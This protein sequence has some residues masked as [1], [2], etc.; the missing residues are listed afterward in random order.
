[1]G[2]VLIPYESIPGIRGLMSVCNCGRSG[3]LE[4]VCSLTA[5]EKCL[6]PFCL[7]GHPGH[8]LSRSDNLRQAAKLARDLAER[9]DPMCKVIFQ[10]QAHAIALFWDVMLNIFDPNALIVGGEA[11]EANDD[12]QRWFIDEIR[13]ALPTQREDPNSRYAQRRYGRCSRRGNRSAKVRPQ[14]QHCV[15]KEH[16]MLAANTHMCREDGQ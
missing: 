7:A 16:T 8:E 13:A 9:G 4:S 12:F 6:L 15:I 1:V 3:D 14:K 5:I 10:V 11:L 2:H